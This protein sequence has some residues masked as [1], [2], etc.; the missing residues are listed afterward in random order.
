MN[1]Q[2]LVEQTVTY[3]IKINGKIYA[4]ENV[5][6]RVNMETGEQFFSPDTVERLHQIILNEETPGGG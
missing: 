3:S 6:A 5:P 2:Y 4:I 1:T